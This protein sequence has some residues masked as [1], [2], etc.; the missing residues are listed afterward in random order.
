MKVHGERRK[1]APD[2]RIED[3]AEFPLLDGEGVWVVTERRRERGQRSGMDD[4][5]AQAGLIT[6]VL[7]G[8]VLLLTGFWILLKY[9]V[10][11]APAWL[12][13]WILYPE[14]LIE[15]LF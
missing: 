4:Y 7:T 2:R 10:I 14:I 1:N 12:P 13:A 9:S 3:T 5:A 6:P 15:Y 8:G 11:E